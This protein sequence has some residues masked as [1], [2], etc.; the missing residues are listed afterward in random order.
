M[1]WGNLYVEQLGRV[2]TVTANM[3]WNDEVSAWSAK[4][5]G[6]V[7]QGL[8]TK[9]KLEVAGV[10]DGGSCIM[11]V[12]AGG[13]VKMVTRGNSLPG[14]GTFVAQAVYFVG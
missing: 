5:C 3:G 2:V 12:E 10:H 6:T 7:P 13:V 8:R 4:T 11:S 14:G 9:A 1:N